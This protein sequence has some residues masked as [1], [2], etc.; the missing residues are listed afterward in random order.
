MC[1][2]RTVLRQAGTALTSYTV[3]DSSQSSSS[4][5]PVSISGIEP[6]EVGLKLESRTVATC[7]PAVAPQ[8]RVA[9][10][11]E[12]ANGTWKYSSTTIETLTSDGI[13][14]ETATAHLGLDDER[15]VHVRNSGIG[16]ETGRVSIVV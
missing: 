9:I 16:A 5:P 6:S 4:E 8:I 12:S 10:G 13:G 3:L 11:A 1:T 7:D 2:N 14:A 15:M